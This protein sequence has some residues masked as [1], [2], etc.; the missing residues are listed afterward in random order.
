MKFYV[1]ICAGLALLACG[2]AAAQVSP[3]VPT[4]ESRLLPQMDW[5]RNFTISEAP[6]AADQNVLALQ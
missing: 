5:R 4:P 2:T 1:S 3:D 6:Q